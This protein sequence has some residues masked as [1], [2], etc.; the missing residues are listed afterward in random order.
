MIIGS[1]GG[2]RPANVARLSRRWIEWGSWIL[3]AP[4]VKCSGGCRQPIL[5]AAHGASGL[6][7]GLAPSTIW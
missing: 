6:A 4:C 5:V 2:S 1:I 3:K 7:L